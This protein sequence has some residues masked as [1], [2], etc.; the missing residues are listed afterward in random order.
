[1]RVVALQFRQVAD[2][3]ELLL[4]LIERAVAAVDAETRSELECARFRRAVAV[5]EAGRQSRGERGVG[6]Q[7]GNPRVG[8]RCRAEVE[9][10]H[11]DLVLE[12]PEPEVGEHRRRDR[13]IHAESQA[14]VADVRDAAQAHQLLAAALAE[15]GR[16]VAEE[17][18]EAVAAEGVEFVGQPPVDADVQR[19]LLECLRAAAT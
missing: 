10:Q 5:D 7:A 13:V 8:G 17:V 3:L 15:R 2:Q 1:M 9:R 12:E 16:T 6:V 18:A 19:V 11:V 4:V 14:V